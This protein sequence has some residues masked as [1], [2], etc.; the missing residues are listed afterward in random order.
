MRHV[1]Q[2]ILSTTKISLTLK[3]YKHKCWQFTNL[4][5]FHFKLHR[6]II[7]DLFFVFKFI[8]FIGVPHCPNGEDESAEQ[9][10]PGMKSSEIESSTVL[11]SQIQTNKSF[12]E[13]RSDEFLCDKTRCIPLSKKCNSEW[14]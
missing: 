3:G 9:C 13:C 5:E 10:P 2:R 4:E 11:I 14:N 12:L 7:F 6:L 1:F 8:E